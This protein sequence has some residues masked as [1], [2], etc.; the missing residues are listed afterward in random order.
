MDG[1]ELDDVVYRKEFMKKLDEL[2]GA[3]LPRP[4]PCSDKRAA[5]LSFTIRASSIR[6]KDK[7]GYDILVINLIHPAKK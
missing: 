3:H 6:M 1:H 5:T 4:P 2:R 7:G